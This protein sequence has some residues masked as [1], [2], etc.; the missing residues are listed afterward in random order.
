MAFETG[1]STSYDWS[2]AEYWNTVDVAVTPEDSHRVAAIVLAKDGGPLTFTTTLDGDTL[3][4]NV[5][6]CDG[7]SLEATLPVLLAESRS[8]AKVIDKV[9]Y[10][11][12]THHVIGESVTTYLPSEVLGMPS[13]PRLCGLNGQVIVRPGLGDDY[14][15]N[16]EDCGVLGDSDPVL[17]GDYIGYPFNAAFRYVPWWDYRLPVKDFETDWN[18]YHRRLRRLLDGAFTI[19]SLQGSV[20]ASRNHSTYAKLKT[21]ILS[22][23][24]IDISLRVGAQ[25]RQ[26]L[27]RETDS[28]R[29]VSV[30]NDGS[31]SELRP[32]LW[33]CKAIHNSPLTFWGLRVPGRHSNSVSARLPI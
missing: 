9:D 26:Q 23:L 13:V 11:S 22:D 6:G 33:R 29:E 3:S 30:R 31:G 17:P 25:A 19:R 4:Q 20:S 27:R 24:Q 16:G 2:E 5:W 12:A 14:H 32:K 18:H 28:P 21:T 15:I 7:V 10:Y 8:V 1:T